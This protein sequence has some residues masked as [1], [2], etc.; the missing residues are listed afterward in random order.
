MFKEI[1]SLNV[2]LI[3]TYNLIKV[4]RFK[5]DRMNQKLHSLLIEDLQ[6]NP[7]EFAGKVVI[8]T[9]AGR[10]IGEQVAHAFAILGASVIVAEISEQGNIVAQNICSRGGNAI[11]IQCDVTSS[12]SI[13]HLVQSVHQIFGLADIVV[14]NAIRIAV[15]PVVN[16]DEA[17][18][19]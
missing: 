1:V 17:L 15:A 9:G 4:F 5:E 10:G 6:L 16:L 7:S 18:W 3:Y 2:L 8:V 12:D 11:Y 14:N 13:Q 19:D